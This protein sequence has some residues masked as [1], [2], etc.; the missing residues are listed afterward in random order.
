MFTL[1]AVTLSLY[2]QVKCSW[3]KVQLYGQHSRLRAGIQH[4]GE[5]T[6]YAS[7]GQHLMFPKK[8][9][10]MFLGCVL[11]EILLAAYR[12]E[13][14]LKSNN[15]RICICSHL[16]WR[17]AMGRPMEPSVKSSKM[18]VGVI[19]VP[20]G[21]EGGIKPFM[22]GRDSSGVFC[23]ASDTKDTIMMFAFTTIKYN[24]NFAYINISGFLQLAHK[25]LLCYTFTAKN[26]ICDGC[27][28]Q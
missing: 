5:Q 2:I 17:K 6:R 19:D 14:K 18:N 9:R 11:E 10:R 24:L 28:M 3:T 20:D 1:V 26:Y 4:V 23:T 27:R 12:L 22:L 15:L 8:T 16:C 7:G 25:I 13:R 21:N